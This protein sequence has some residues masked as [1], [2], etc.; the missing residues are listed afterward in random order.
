MK[1]SKRDPKRLLLSTEKVRQLQ[2]VSDDQ[3]EGVAG[4]MRCQCNTTG[5]SNTT[6]PS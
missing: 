1:K 4:G 6:F 3:L 2:P 5:C